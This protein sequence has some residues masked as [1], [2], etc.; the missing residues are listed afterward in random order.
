MSLPETAAT[1]EP[2]ADTTSLP[3]NQ[4]R[5]AAEKGKIELEAKEIERRLKG[6]WYDGR[7]FVQAIVGA[8][9]AAAL[10]ATWIMGYM[11]PILTRRQ[12]IAA[13][14]VQIQ[15]KEN[16]RQRLENQVRTA[17]LEQTNNLM[18]TQLESM[19][20]ANAGLRQQEAEAE[21]Q[22]TDLKEQITAQA[23]LLTTFAGKTSLSATERARAAELA[24]HAQAQA[25]QLQQQITNLRQQQ[26]NTKQRSATIKSQLTSSALQDTTWK[27]ECPNC[28]TDL[29]LK[30]VRL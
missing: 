29:Q 19:A 22:A 28:S 10:L 26:A 7:F 13:L 9:V 3:E 18:K 2:P 8:V 20:A 16:E 27:I 11:Q 23:A 4:R 5:L 14:D 15:T 24:G 30:Y 6:R 21:R 1:S 17:S 12:E 25:L